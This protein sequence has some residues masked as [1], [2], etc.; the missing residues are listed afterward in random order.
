[1]KGRQEIRTNPEIY[2]VPAPPSRPAASFPS[3]PPP[4]PA[5]AAPHNKPDSLAY[6]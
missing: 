2:G 6:A 4:P 5:A 3:P 1:Y